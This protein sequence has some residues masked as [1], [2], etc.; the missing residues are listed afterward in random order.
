MTDP[1][2]II[3]VCLALHV[4][5][6]ARRISR[7]FDACLEPHGI[8]VS[9][10]NILSAIAALDAAPLVAVAEIL[11]VDPSTLSR[12]LKPLRLRGLIQAVG[13]R[14]RAG[15]TL[16]LTLKGADVFSAATMAW[17]QA[18]TDLTVLLG[19]ARVGRTLEMLESLERLPD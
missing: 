6:A 15:L 1:A 4:R 8:D 13:G 2:T 3:E 7:R 12:T 9:Q 19:E 5:R 14:G 11:D 18:Q 10:F 16:S 17:K